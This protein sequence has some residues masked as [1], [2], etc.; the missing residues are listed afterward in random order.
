M[1]R[2]RRSIQE[3]H[4][5]YTHSL[6]HPY[7]PLNGRVA[8]TVSFYFSENPCCHGDASGDRG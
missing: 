1:Y 2:D 8:M 3:D 6:P 7:D 4:P 5:L